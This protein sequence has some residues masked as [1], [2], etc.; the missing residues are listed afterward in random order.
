MDNCLSLIYIQ[1]IQNTDSFSD[2]YFKIFWSIN[3]VLIGRVKTGCILVIFYS[4]P[5]IKS[6]KNIKYS[7]SKT[8]LYLKPSSC[9]SL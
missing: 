7:E 9:P 3:H 5:A 4:K 2:M 6:R 8:S 1:A